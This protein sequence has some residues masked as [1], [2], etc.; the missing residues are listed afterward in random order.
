MRS[1][2]PSY[3]PAGPL[4]LPRHLAAAAVAAVL[5]LG[6]GGA[7]AQGTISPDLAAALTQPSGSNDPAPSPKE[8]GYPAPR[9][10]KQP[11]VPGQSPGTVV[12]LDRTWLR[13]VAGRT[14]VQAIVY[15]R[16]EAVGGFAS[17]RSF[18]VSSGGAV[19]RE[20]PA[21]SALSIVAPKNA[22]YQIAARTDVSTISPNRVALR[23]ATP[24]AGMAMD[25]NAVNLRPVPGMNQ[26]SALALTTGLSGPTPPGSGQGSGVTIAVLDSGVMA[27]HTSFLR[28]NG[29]RRVEA[30]VDL[31][32]AQT[33][34]WTTGVDRSAQSVQD[35]LRS[36]PRADFADGHG[37]GTH[38]A[39][40]AAGAGT[41]AGT[42]ANPRGIAPEASIFDVRVLGENGVGQIDEVLAGIDCVIRRA[43]ELGVRV[44]NLSLATDS[45]ESY[46]TDPLCQA[47]RIATAAGITVVVAAGN[48]GANEIK[49]QRVEVY[50]RIGSPGIDP[51]VITVGSV[52]W[53]NTTFRSDDSV[54]NFSS[55][56][57]TRG[58]GLSR[59]GA[60]VPDNLL[61][62]DLVAP[63]NRVLGASAAGPD[64]RCRASGCGRRTRG[65]CAQPAARTVGPPSTAPPSSPPG[66]RNSP[67]TTRHASMP[68]SCRPSP[69]TTIPA[70]TRRTAASSRRPASRRPARTS[71]SHGLRACTPAGARSRCA[72]AA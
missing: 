17:L 10:P 65:S 8:G 15:A 62:P 4:G 1:L 37:H 2:F 55:R 41:R 20:Y 51:S 39:S 46:V 35:C 28:S 48:F 9:E 31:V 32:Q 69:C 29:S 3:T 53:R 13:D 23:T 36:N 40:V 27:V 61:K 50:G 12:S 64:G 57:P 71:A 52:N 59:S 47:V 16:P 49:G 67:S 43:P 6:L 18:V 30:S 60:W 72:G 45:R 34:A 56:G 25:P 19:R 42:T 66:P 22:I 21:L 14:L 11:Q 70:A 24:V 68:S 26:P 7:R 44:M 38:V 58:L 54:N 63:G 5:A 33:D